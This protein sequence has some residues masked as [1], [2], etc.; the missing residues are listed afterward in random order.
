MRGGS[1]PVRQSFLNFFQIESLPPSDTDRPLHAEIR[2]MI[3]LAVM[4]LIV[5]MRGQ[6]DQ[7]P[8][9]PLILRKYFARQHMMN[10]DCF[11]RNHLRPL[12]LLALIMISPKNRLPQLQPPR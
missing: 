7:I 4:H 2:K 12:R 11:I 9:L 3:C 5:S 6:A 1:L 8:L 10:D